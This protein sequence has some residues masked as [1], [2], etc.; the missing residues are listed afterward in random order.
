MAYF[1]E[2]TEHYR[3]EKTLGAPDA[4]D[5]DDAGDRGEGRVFR[6]ADPLTGTPVTLK[7]IPMADAPPESA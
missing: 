6:A 3:I 4:G 7:L 5:A 2:I 1:R